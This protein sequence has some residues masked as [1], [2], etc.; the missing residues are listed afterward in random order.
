MLL[1]TPNGIRNFGR[2]SYGSEPDKYLYVFPPTYTLTFNSKP[3]L[4]DNGIAPKY[5]RNELTVTWIVP[6]DILYKWSFYET[7]IEQNDYG[8]NPPMWDGEIAPLTIDTSIQR[9]KDILMKPRLTLRCEYQGLGP[10]GTNSNGQASSNRKDRYYGFTIGANNDVNFGPLPLDFKWRNLAAQQAV[11]LTWVVAFHTVNH[12]IYDLNNKIYT[13]NNAGHYLELSWSRSYDIDELG[14]ATITTSGRYTLNSAVARVIDGPD[15]LNPF[16]ATTDHDR[17]LVAFPVPAYCK[18][19]T[20]KFQ[21]DPTGRSTSF[22]LV[23]KQHTVENALPPKCIDMDLTHEV[24]S[25]LIGGKFEGTGFMRWNNVIQGNITLPP[26]EPFVTAYFMF[27]FYA[28][29]RLMRVQKNGVA[30]PFP[31]P[32]SKMLTNEKKGSS[33]ERTEKDL[34]VRNLITKISYKESLFNRNHTFRL[35]YLG[36]YDRDRLIQQSGLFTP[37]YNYKQTASGDAIDWFEP[38]PL[39]N[40]VEPWSKYFTRP[41]IPP[42]STASSNLYNQWQSYA[43]QFN[44]GNEHPN[45]DAR[46]FS[47]WNVYGYTGLIE[48]GGPYVYYPTDQVRDQVKINKVKTDHKIPAWVT[49]VDTPRNDE[50]AAYMQND[51]TPLGDPS[52]PLLEALQPNKS[53]IHHENTFTIIEDVNTFQV[54]RQSYATSI[55]KSMKTQNGLFPPSNMD[56]DVFLHHMGGATSDLPPSTDYVAS[57]NSQPI[58]TIVMTGYAIRA[59]FPPSIPSAFQYKGSALVRCGRSQIS[60][61][62]IAQGKVPVYL[63]TWSIPYYANTS[64]HSNF[65]KDLESTAF[66]GVLT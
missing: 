3:V 11:E 57:Y 8:Q 64:V 36:T 50:S 47:A 65:F 14:S 33:N 62:Q 66:A 9:I 53:Y 5:N 22:T 41:T 1:K 39:K 59:G 24:S 56:K 28:R 20:Q 58:T 27:W 19:V 10:A 18:R 44:K 26:G 31:N 37:L 55:D 46:P 25:Q 13:E 23:D 4:G 61:K 30:E 7:G 34:S 60:V 48:D 52:V 40:H 51:Y 6:Y 17:I 43:Q 54:T 32:A 29:Q 15:K 12:I 16:G 21:H 2:L 42:P 49:T 45:F 35:E 63:A 38:D